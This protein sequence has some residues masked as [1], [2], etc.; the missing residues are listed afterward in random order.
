M[1][2]ECIETVMHKKIVFEEKRSMLIVKN[3]Q[4]LPVT[5]IRVDDCEIKDGRRCDYL[6]QANDLEHFVELK[7]QDIHYAI[8]QI[9]STIERL[10]QVS[11]RSRKMAF[12][13]TARSPLSAA[14]I[15]VLRAKF[16]K[17]Y[18]S[19]LVVKNSPWTHTL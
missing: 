10:S 8:Q 16:K 11:K 7:G 9:T 6:F 15:Q 1:K 14:S 19:D 18:G 3:S 5:K 2:E 4:Q 17:N 12:V 13:I